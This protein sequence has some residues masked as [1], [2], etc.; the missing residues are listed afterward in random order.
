MLKE[1]IE[2]VKTYNWDKDGGLNTLEIT[3]TNHAKT[4]VEF[5]GWAITLG[6][7]IG[8]VPS[9]K[10]ENAKLWKS[11]YTVEKEGRKHPTLMTRTNRFLP[12]LTKPTWQTGGRILMPVPVTQSRFPAKQETALSFCAKNFPLPRRRGKTPVERC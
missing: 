3:V 4:P 9:E 7:G 2:I 12:Y 11:V 10:D 5:P 1:G 8:T 6:P